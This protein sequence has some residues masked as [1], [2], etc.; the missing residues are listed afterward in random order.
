MVSCVPPDDLFP[1]RPPAAEMEECTFF[2]Q[3]NPRSKTP[4][5]FR[6][7]SAADPFRASSEAGASSRH[8]AGSAHSGRS[9]TPQPPRVND[10][11]NFNEF[12]DR[13]QRFLMAKAVNV[14]IA[15]EAAAGDRRPAMA[16]GTARI[17]QAQAAAAARSQTPP[18]GRERDQYDKVWGGSVHRVAFVITLLFCLFSCLLLRFRAVP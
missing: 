15:A 18:P 10:D 17:L 1:P 11:L 5:R 8:Y 6:A 16:P 12:L 14:E 13:Q 9:R 3:T 4:G 7:S 2:P